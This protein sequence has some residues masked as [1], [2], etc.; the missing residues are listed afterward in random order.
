MSR[1]PDW[2]LHLMQYLAECA[3][4]PFEVG[5]HDCALFWAGAVEA[6]TGVDPADKWRGKYTTIAGGLKLLK[7]AGFSDHVAVAASMFVEIPV[8]FAAPGDLAVLPAA[9]DP[10]SLAM[11][12]IVQGEGIYHLAP[13]GLAVAPLISATT[14]FRVI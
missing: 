9:D 8:A 12:G 11:A 5:Q 1:K 7:K 4:R 10:S 13:T 6:M 14:A 2:K 3:R